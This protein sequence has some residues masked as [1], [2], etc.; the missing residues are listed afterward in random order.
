MLVL[1]IILKI[2]ISTAMNQVRHTRTLLNTDLPQIV[3]LDSECFTPSWSVGDYAAEMANGTVI[4]YLPD[5]VKLAGLISFRYLV[6]EVEILRIAVLEKFRRQGIANTLLTAMELRLLQSLYGCSR[7]F[8]EVRVSNIIAQKFYEK[9]GF[10][11]IAL[12]VNYYSDGETAVV[13]SKNCSI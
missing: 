4:G 8:L 5:G 11:R 13:F 9:Y 2:C 10:S 12:R 3:A 6:D 1:H 7:I